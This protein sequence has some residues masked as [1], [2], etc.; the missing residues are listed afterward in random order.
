MINE[1][2]IFYLLWRCLKYYYS[3]EQS[4]GCLSILIQGV[5]TTF[6]DLLIFYR[7]MDFLSIL[8]IFTYFICFR[9]FLR[10]FGYFCLNLTIFDKFYYYIRQRHNKGSILDGFVFK[11]NLL[12]VI[13]RLRA[14]AKG[15]LWLGPCPN[16]FNKTEMDPYASRVN[17]PSHL[18]D[19]LHPY[20]YHPHH[21]ICIRRGF[22]TDVC[23]WEALFLQLYDCR[24]RGAFFLQCQL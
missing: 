16:V 5:T 13:L 10:F 6:I 17:D 21:P 22:Q 20:H 23:V 14:C 3:H 24:G 15:N 7:F 2:N 19:C 18:R 8:S 1:V 11:T 4:M 9:C 12:L